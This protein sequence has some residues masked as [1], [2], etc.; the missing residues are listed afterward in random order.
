[1]T[2]KIESFNRSE[3]PHEIVARGEGVLAPTYARP[4]HLFVE[5]YGSTLIDAE[6]HKYLDMTSGIAVT[7]LG[8]GAQVASR[9][10]H[11]ASERLGHVSNLFH[12]R[13]PIELASDLVADSFADRVFFCNSGAE[14]VEAAIKFARLAHPSRQRIVYFRGSFH[15]RTFGALA[16]TD[17]EKIRTPFEPLPGGFERVDWRDP[18]ALE[19]INEH[20]A[21]VIVEPIQ[22]EGGI[23]TPPSGFL[24]GLRERCDATAAALIFDEI[25]CGLGRTGHLWAHEPS[26]VTPDLMTLAKPLANGLPIGAVLITETIASH[27][28]PGC[29]G[30][31]FGGGPV[32]THV[33][34]AVF[35]AIRRPGFLQRVREKGSFLQARLEKAAKSSQPILEVRGEGL[36]LGVELEGQVSE[37]V[38]A[39][40]KR[41]VLFVGAGQNTLRFLPP[42]IVSE[43]E[44]STAVRVLEDAVEEVF[45]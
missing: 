20:T 3:D 14:A 43:E 45:A 8:H 33:A 40:R 1:M 17:K 36:M 21:G 37:V 35:H 31:T 6:G 24:A 30:T 27:L 34:R 23:R 42:L 2:P 28:S 32:V 13:A 12:T 5:G 22:G 15:G 29:H 11:E 18:K 25:Q 39:A 9:A 41:G 19:A 44:L 16:A 7:A 26:G 10:Q 4:S 38:E